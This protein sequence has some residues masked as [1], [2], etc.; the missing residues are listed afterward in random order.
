MSD[1]RL[2]LEQIKAAARA[3]TGGKWVVDRRWP[4]DHQLYVAQDYNGEPGGRICEVFMNC[5]VREPQR[6]AN[7][8]YLAATH[9]AV[10]LALVERL[11]RAEATAL[12]ALDLALRYGGID[13]E[14]H[15]AWAIDQ[16]CRALLGERYDA[17]V[18]KA[19]AGE[20][21]PET[22]T[23]DVGLAP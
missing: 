5:L 16:M 6:T 14:H 12:T 4:E 23:W 7:A 18:M 1:M 17:W 3:A 20:D 8:E 21:G 22:Y 10:V 2:D 19:K 11:E 9:P 15:K 13:G